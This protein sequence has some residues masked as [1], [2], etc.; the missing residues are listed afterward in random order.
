MSDRNPTAPADDIVSA[1]GEIILYPTEDGRSR[2]ECR[3]EQGTLWLSQGA[4]VALYQIDK[5]N[6]SRHLRAIFAEGELDEKAVVAYFATTGLDG[7]TYQVG[8]Y[9][10]DAVIAVGYRVRSPR[11]TQFRQWATERLREYLVKGFTMDDERL[12]NPPGPGVPDHFDELLERI[13]DIR[14]SE[15]RMYLRVREIFALAADYRPGT[16]ETIAFFQT[17]QNKLH[18]AATGKTAPE[19][20]QARADHTQPNMGLRTWKGQGVRKGDVTV[21][22][23]YLNED[24]ITELNRIVVMFLDYAED[25][26]KRRKQ[27]YMH[28]WPKKLDAFLAFNERS[29]LPGLGKWKREDADAHAERE[30]ERFAARR[31]TVLE[32]EAETEAL[33]QLEDVARRLAKGTADMAAGPTSK[34]RA[35]AASRPTS[36]KRS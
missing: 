22:K 13:R 7:K 28:E 27:I 31:R 2:V 10:L 1:R 30:Y 20:I 14:A 33:K 5:S 3:F 29:V 15:R 19:L 34:G 4:M 9:H 36:K 12:K 18:F 6:V 23:N 25:Q 32:Q 35:D 11:G 26:T 17:M 8:H 16:P 24:E 21:A